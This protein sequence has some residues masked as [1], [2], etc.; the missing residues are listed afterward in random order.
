MPGTYTI[1]LNGFLA[2]MDVQEVYRKASPLEPNHHQCPGFCMPPTQNTALNIQTDLG[3]G[4][5]S[6]QQQCDNLILLG[7]LC[8]EAG[9]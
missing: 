5:T 7:Y 3:N 9:Q 1:T 6:P 2:S 4:N 8:S